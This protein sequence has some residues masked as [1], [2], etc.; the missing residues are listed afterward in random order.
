VA[1]HPVPQRKASNKNSIKLLDFKILSAFLCSKKEKR[2]K[3]TSGT[4]WGNV[5][6][7]YIEKITILMFLIVYIN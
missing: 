1:D 3:N 4:R 7:N 5:L 6:I 2:Y